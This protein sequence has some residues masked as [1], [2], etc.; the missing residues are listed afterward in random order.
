MI[1]FILVAAVLFG[2]SFALLAA[3]G[4]EVPRTMQTFQRSSSAE[5]S[6]E[7]RGSRLLVMG[8]IGLIL[9][10]IVAAMAFYALR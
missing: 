8:L 1:W 9:A 10:G 7:R 6:F 4:A 3:G 2:V 5:Q